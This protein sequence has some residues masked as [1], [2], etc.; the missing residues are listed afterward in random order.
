[1]TVQLP[2]TH[3]ADDHG[4]VNTLTAANSG[5]SRDSQS[6]AS[7]KHTRQPQTNA[8]RQR[9]G[10]VTPAVQIPPTP[11]RLIGRTGKG[12]PDHDRRSRPGAR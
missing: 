4:V 5:I 7:D 9:P 12:A 6:E 2:L 3:A 1:M 10:E 11:C 8:G